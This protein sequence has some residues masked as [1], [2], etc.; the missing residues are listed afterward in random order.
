MTVS[1][2]GAARGDQARPPGPDPSDLTVHNRSIAPVRANDVLIIALDVPYPDNYGGAKDMWQRLRVLDKH[3][4]ALSLLATYKD[5]RRRAAFDA[6]PE[7]RLFKQYLLFRSRPWR[8]LASVYPYAVGS[9]SLTTTQVGEVAA[10]FGQ[11]TFGAV[12]VEGLQ[13]LGTFLNLRTHL[14][15]RKALVRPFNRESAYQF[16]LARNEPHRLRRAFLRFD[17]CKFYLFERFGRWKHAIDA[18]LFISSEEIDHPNF[19]RIKRRVLVR[20]TCPVEGPPTFVND[21][22]RRENLL[23]YVGNL[24]LADN[25]AAV[26]TAYREL[27]DLLRQQGWRFAV[28]GRTDDPGILPEL[29]DDPQIT[30]KFNLTTD[31]LNEL[32][33][34]A[35]IFVCFSEN[36][37]G[38]KLKLLE[39]IQGGLP[40]IANDDAVA[41]S[42]LASATLVLRSDD[43]AARGTLVDLVASPERWQNFRLAAYRVWQGVNERA[44][45]EYVKVFDQ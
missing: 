13:A 9:R 41:G 11:T 10:R 4:Y 16:G 32:Y 19:A 3:G 43:V 6:S 42:D 37:A 24:R 45:A 8:G 1:S 31:E 40:V 35:K 44:T 21:F 2:F 30:R 27:R 22:A 18:V 25:R 38:A 5:E 23:L 14:R 33:A 12:E 28:C 34:R 20:P 15:Y 39:A 26:L 7:S 17:A 36:R 29:K